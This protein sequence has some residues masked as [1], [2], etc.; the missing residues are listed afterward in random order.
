[1]GSEAGG[2]ADLAFISR[3]V[4]AAGPLGSGFVQGRAL[5]EE[6]SYQRQ[7]LEDRAAMAELQG[8]DAR[9]RGEEEAAAVRRRTRQVI[10]SQRAAAA[11]QNLEVDAG[12]A[13]QL[14]ADAAAVGALDAETARNNAWR[15]EFGLRAEADELRL[16][17][18]IAEQDGKYRGRMTA[19]TGGLL[20]AKE[21]MEGGHEYSERTRKRSRRGSTVNGIPTGKDMSDPRNR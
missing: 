9:R 11:G 6:G 13:A 21:L 8:K 2:Y 20:F 14:Q 19:A 3:G 17:G 1:M 18:R 4:A 12:S 5:R 7:V 16:A 15:E 10:G